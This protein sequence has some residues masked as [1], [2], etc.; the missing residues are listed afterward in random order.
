MYPTL[1]EAYYG[2]HTVECLSEI[3]HNESCVVESA[4]APHNL[5]EEELARISENVTIGYTYLVFTPV[6]K[7]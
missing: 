1:C 3:W 6:L 2:P 7:I 5:P 4:N